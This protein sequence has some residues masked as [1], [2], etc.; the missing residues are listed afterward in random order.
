VDNKADTTYVD[1]ELNKKVDKVTGKQLS[2]EDFTTT[3][4]NKLANIEDGANKYTLPN[5]TTT[6]LGGIKVGANLSIAE[7]G[8]LSAVDDDSKSTFIIKQELF[9]A[10]EGQTL[11]NLTKGHYQPNTNTISVYLYGG[12]QPNIAL[13][14]ISSSSFEINEP[15]KA[16]DVVLVEYI[17]LSSAAPYPIHGNDHLLDGYDP[18][19]LATVLS[20]GL[21]SKDDKFKLDGIENGANK[22]THPSTHPASM[23][24]ESTTKRFVSDAEKSKWNGYYRGNWDYVTFNVY[25]DAD[26]YYPVVLTG[27]NM[28]EA[29]M[30]FLEIYRAYS[31]KAPDTWNTP[32]HKGGLNLSIHYSLAGWGGQNYELQITLSQTYS[33]MV[34]D[35]ITASPDTSSIIVWLRGG[36]AQYQLRRQSKDVAVTVYD[37]VQNDLPFKNKEGTQYETIYNS[38]TTIEDW[39]NF[40]GIRKL[41]TTENN[42]YIG[43]GYRNPK[44]SVKIYHENNKPTPSDIGASPAVHT[45]DDRYYTESEVN[46]LL[47]GKVDNSKVLTNV[48]AN[49]KFTD[50]ITTINGNTGAISKA[51]IVALGIPAQDTV[52][53]HPATHPASMITE[54]ATKRFVSDTEKAAWNAKAEDAHNH[55]KADITD[56]PTKLSEFQNDIGAGAGLNIVVSPTEP[57]GLS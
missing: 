18:I 32:T 47:G 52:Y 41:L 37:G 19:P 9:V 7:D 35:V 56:M 15:L 31:W 44:N 16:G 40:I 11:F 57:A 48:P 25:G 55:V 27:L 10:T 17:E 42:L 5:A 23:I 22:Y 14:E 33:K 50:T 53:T 6:V 12:K 20:E 8:T 29:T 45:H 49:A 54:S 51:D 28:N 30:S 2:T 34:A 38:T 36:D 21:M 24:T 39:F 26:V 3:E 1:T 46:T 4:K 13:N 43:G